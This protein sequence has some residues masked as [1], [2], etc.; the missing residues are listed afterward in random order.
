METG[1]S[2]KDP[3]HLIGRHE[4]F[5]S[6]APVE[7]PLIGAWLGG[8]FPAQQFPHGTAGWREGQALSARDIVLAPFEADYEDLFQLHQ[9]MEDDFIYFGS[10]YWGIP[11]L[12]A[13]LGCAVHAGKTT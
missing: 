13:I 7:R 5:L 11:W 4:A 8:Y 12:E 2:D 10:A 3:T 1:V 6:C 9:D